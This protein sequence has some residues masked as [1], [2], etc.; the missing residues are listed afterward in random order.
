MPRLDAE[1][2]REHATPMVCSSASL[3]LQAGEDPAG[4]ARMMGHMTTKMLFE[5]Y[6]RFIEYR[7]RQDGSAYLEASRRAKTVHEAPKGLRIAT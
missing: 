3:M 6:R 7:T 1:A 2:F 5:R 4:I